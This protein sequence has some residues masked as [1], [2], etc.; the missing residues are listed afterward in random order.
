MQVFYT[1]IAVTEVQSSSINNSST[2]SDTDV[3]LS[4]TCLQ[5]LFRGVREL[6]KIQLMTVTRPKVTVECAGV[7][8]ESVPIKNINQN[9]NFPNPVQFVDVVSTDQKLR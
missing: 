4:R 9:S 1:L 5:M 2:F 7:Q 8:V 3:D 6:K